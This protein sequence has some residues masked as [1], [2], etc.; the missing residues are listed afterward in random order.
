MPGRR[1]SRDDRAR[2]G[3]A[4]ELDVEQ[5]PETVPEDDDAVPEDDD[6]VP[7]DDDAV[8]ED[9]A[10]ADDQ[11]GTG[12]RRASRPPAAAVAQAA[13]RAIAELIG[14]PPEGVTAL[15]PTEEGWHVAV[16]VVEDQRVPSSA[17]ILATY[18]A[19]LDMEGNLLSYR[20]TRRY[21]RGRA[22]P[23]EGA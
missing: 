9:V 23:S 11:A 16:E 18:E 20:R 22:D 21:Q 7:E 17:D 19:E 2:G 3:R 15:E 8:A 1:V 4:A 13:I 5:D 10:P 12:G 14:R 6:A